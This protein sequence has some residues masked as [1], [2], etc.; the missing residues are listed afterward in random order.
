VEA[1]VYALADSAQAMDFIDLVMYRD[2]PGTLAILMEDNALPGVCVAV[3]GGDHPDAVFSVCVCVTEVLKRNPQIAGVVLASVRPHDSPDCDDIDR[4][5]ELVH[6]FEQLGVELL[7][8]FVVGP[9]FAVGMRAITGCV[10]AWE[11]ASDQ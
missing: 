11:T 7:E 8:W 4:W 2:C 5:F 1:A 10:S 6:D 9:A 3:D